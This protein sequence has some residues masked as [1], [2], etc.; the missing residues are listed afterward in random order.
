MVERET[1]SREMDTQ[2]L[3]ALEKLVLLLLYDF[4][5]AGKSS[6]TVSAWI[7]YNIA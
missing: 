4:S 1:S 2:I 6:F 3:F 5:Q 7:L